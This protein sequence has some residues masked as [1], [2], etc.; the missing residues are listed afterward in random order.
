MRSRRRSA[1]VAA[2][3]L[4]LICLGIAA[5]AVIHVVFGVMS[6]AVGLLPVAAPI[7]LILLAGLALLGVRR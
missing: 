6:F 1:D 2:V 5:T 4:G 3:L 7:L